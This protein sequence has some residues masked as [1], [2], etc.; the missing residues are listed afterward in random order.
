MT[1]SYSSLRETFFDECDALLGKALSLHA[2]LA[3]DA[4]GAAFKEL[5][6]CVHGVAGAAASMDMQQ[7]ASLA[8][9]L[10]VVLDPLRGAG[11]WPD[12]GCRARC[13]E[14]LQE[15]AAAVGLLRAGRTPDLR[16]MAVLESGLR[17]AVPS[18][19]NARCEDVRLIVFDVSR[20]LA[21]AE[22]VVEHVLDEL[23]QAGRVERV[24]EDEV[25]PDGGRGAWRIRFSGAVSDDWIRDLLGG[26]AEPGSLLVVPAVGGEGALSAGRHAVVACVDGPGD[27]IDERGVDGEW[28]V[29]FR[30]AAQCYL[31]AA[32]RVLDVRPY[33]GEFVL[34]GLPAFVR[35]LIGVGEE[36]VPLVDGRKALLG[37]QDAGEVPDAAAMLVL[38]APHGMVALLADEAGRSLR[39]TPGQLRMP[40]AL[41]GVFAACPVVAMHFGAEGVS[42]V[43]DVMRFCAYLDPQLKRA[44]TAEPEAQ[45]A[46]TGAQMNEKGS[47]GAK[48]PLRSATIGPAGPPV[49]P[50]P[51][52][53]RS[54]PAGRK[55]LEEEWGRP[56]P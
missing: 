36:A 27:D 45:R 25:A 42:L 16:R 8:R 15:L 3:T 12:A 56:D 29:G 41:E 50:A 24:S 26:V 39:V 7:L 30:V 44:T 31:C 2:T 23:A 5:H 40:A 4:N 19:A 54:V 1:D 28:Y 32:E 34:P 38:Q 46:M 10:E 35:G 14:A 21:G 48:K 49:P 52:R 20:S 37:L 51:R 17:S 6:R 55:T 53:G 47:E 13:G 9:A 11:A 33:H 43:L 18:S 22:I